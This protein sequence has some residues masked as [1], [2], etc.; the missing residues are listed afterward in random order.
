MKTSRYTRHRGMSLVSITHLFQ[1]SLGYPNLADSWIFRDCSR[2][3]NVILTRRPLHRYNTLFQSHLFTQ[4]RHQFYFARAAD[5]TLVETSH[6]QSSKSYPN[7]D[8]CGGTD[9]RN[10]VHFSLAAPENTFPANVWAQC[11]RSQHSPSR[12]AIRS[13]GGRPYVELC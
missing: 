9:V 6:E 2:R 10:A 13:L 5:T 1:N 4:Y 8:I 3:Q 12:C 11:L 7:L